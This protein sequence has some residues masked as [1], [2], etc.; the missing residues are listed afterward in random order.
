MT[1]S[2]KNRQNKARRLQELS[3][4]ARQRYLNTGGDPLHSANDKHLTNE[5]KEEFKTLLSQVF[6]QEYINRYLEQNQ[7]LKSRQNL[8]V[9]EKE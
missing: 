5:E 3:Q 9:R 4:L 8:G 7:P 1:N 2:E 6:D